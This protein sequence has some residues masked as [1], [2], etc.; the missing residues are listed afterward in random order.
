MVLSESGGNGKTFAENYGKDYNNALNE[1]VSR[2]DD[3]V[4]RALTVRKQDDDRAKL[5]Y[6]EAEAQDLKDG[7]FDADPARLSELAAEARNERSP[8]NC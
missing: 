4:Q 6:M 5:A 8:G 7:S 2:Q 1:A 3:D